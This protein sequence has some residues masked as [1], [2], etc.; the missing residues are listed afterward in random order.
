MSVNAVRSMVELNQQ[1]EAVLANGGLNGIESWLGRL[2]PESEERNHGHI[3]DFKFFIKG[4]R[5]RDK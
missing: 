3:F 4:L 5:D 1:T 2:S